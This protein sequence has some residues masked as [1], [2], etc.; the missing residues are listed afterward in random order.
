MENQ[1]ENIFD[2]IETKE[3]PSGNVKDA[4]LS[5]LELIQNSSQLVEHFFGHYFNTLL[6]IFKK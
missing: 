4:V 5:D 2:K 3:V 6:E 1:K